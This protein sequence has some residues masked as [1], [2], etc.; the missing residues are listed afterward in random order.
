[1]WMK[2]PEELT[3]IGIGGT[4]YMPDQDG[5]VGPIPDVH[6]AQAKR[7]GLVET[8]EPKPPKLNKNTNLPERP[9]A[10][11]SGKGKNK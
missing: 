11:P 1:M 4:E 8:G 10:A 9:K 7:H 5:V 6:V 3:S 2:L